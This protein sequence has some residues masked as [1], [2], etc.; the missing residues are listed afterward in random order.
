M[1]SSQSSLRRQV[2]AFVSAM[3]VLALVSSSISLLRITEANRL[4][5]SIG[6]V[7]VPLGRILAQIQSDS[8][9]Y[10]R[11]LERGL[12]RSHWKDP[13]WHATAPTQWMEQGLE[14]EFKSLEELVKRESDWAQAE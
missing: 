4:L 5:E 7:V 11:E 9:G 10:L 2:L 12:A 6:R 14:N 3:V 13:K 8:E 1:L